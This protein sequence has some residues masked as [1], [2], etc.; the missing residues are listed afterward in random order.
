MGRW[1]ADWAPSISTGT[2]RACASSMMRRTGL[3]VPSELDRWTIETIFGRPFS[4][5]SYSS[6]SNSPSSFMGTTRSTAPVAS[7]AICQGTMLEWCSIAERMISS[8]GRRLVRP[9]DWATRLMASVAP[10]TKTISRGSAAFRNRR[11]LSRAASYSR[12]AC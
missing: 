3:I 5:F 1:P 6:R 7:Q 4:S 2:P 12:V 11:T 9:Q 10:R 8:P